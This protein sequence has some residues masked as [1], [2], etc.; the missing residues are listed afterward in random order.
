MV[1]KKC[2]SSTM[3]TAYYQERKKYRAYEGQ[4]NRA[5]R[6]LILWEF[7]Y[8]EWCAW[9]EKYLGP[10][11]MKK[12]GHFA[13]QYVMARYFDD[14]PYAV[15]NV[16]CITASENCAEIRSNAKKRYSRLRLFRLKYGLDP[17]KPVTCRQLCSR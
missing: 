1:D 8:D 13:H 14:G 9:W 10:N 15:H 17:D 3:T 2:K 16:K 5:R 11:W 6:R 12:R 7:E 4:R